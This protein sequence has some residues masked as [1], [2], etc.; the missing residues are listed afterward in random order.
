MYLRMF[1]YV[2]ICTCIIYTCIYIYIQ[3]QIYIHVNTSICIYINLLCIVNH[4]FA[5]WLMFVVH[6]TYI[7]AA[8]TYIRIY[9][10]VLHIRIYVWTDVRGAC[11]IRIRR[12]YVYTCTHMH[13]RIYLTDVRGARCI[14]ILVV[15]M[16]HGTHTWMSH[17][18]PIKESW[19]RHECVMADMA[20]SHGSLMNASTNHSTRTRGWWHIYE[21]VTYMNKSHIWTCLSTHIHMSHSHGFVY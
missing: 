9:I 17:G 18:T 8:Y 13:I 14:H 12:I 20:V 2:C 10:C 19:H 15:W 21:C 11:R 1:T 3:L 7:Y 6:V 4:F 16:S 5:S